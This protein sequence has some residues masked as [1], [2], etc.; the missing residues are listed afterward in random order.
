MAD[1]LNVKIYPEDKVQ[2]FPDPS[3]GIGSK[4][5]ITRATAIYVTDAKKLTVYR[6]WQK[7][8][9]DLLKEK[10]IGLLGQDSVDP[11]LDTWLR[12]NMSLTITRVAEVELTEE[13]VI[14]YKVITKNDPTRYRGEPDIVQREGKNGQKILTYKVR[15]QDGVEVSRT[16]IDTQTTPAQDKIVLRGTKLKIKETITGRGTWY[17]QGY[18]AASHVWPK[19]THIRVTNPAN[20]RSIETVIDDY[21]ESD[22]SVIDLKK[23]LFEKLADPYGTMPNLVVDWVLN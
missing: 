6:T 15:R 20:G 5:V 7:T 19:G 16:L 13:E 10:N 12:Y 4:I 17:D 2:T 1:G 14:T 11:S 18:N 21:M 3:L 22:Q 8:I 23:S 9:S